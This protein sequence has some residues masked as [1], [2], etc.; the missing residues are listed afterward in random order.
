VQL[1]DLGAL[2][3][4]DRIR[5]GVFSAEDYVRACAERIEGSDRDLGAWVH[6]D[7]DQALEQA[8]SMDE[9]RRRGHPLGLLHGV[10]VGVKD[11]F[12]TSDMPTALGTDIHEGRI[13]ASDAAVVEKL[14]EAGAVI[15]GKTATAEYAFMQPAATRN[16]HDH[17]RTPGGSSSGSA[18]AVAAG[19]V[20]L[21]VGTQTNGSVI[22]PAAYCGVYGFKPSRGIISRRGALQTSQSLDQVGVFG[23]SLGDVARLADALG[24]YDAADPASFLRPRPRMYEGSLAEVPVEPSFAWFDL[25]FNDRLSEAAREGFEELLASLG[26]RVERLPAPKSFQSVVECHKVVHEYELY[27]NLREDIERHGERVSAPLRAVAERARGYGEGRYQ[28]ALAMMAGAED[29][30]DEF[31][32]DYDAILTPAAAGEA[33]ALEAGTGDPIFCTIWTFSGLP[34]LTLPLLVGETGLPVGV[35]MVGSANADDRL[36]RTARWLIRQLQED[37]LDDA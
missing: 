35:Q 8:R 19:Q 24:G 30:F 13:P 32:C 23:R 18:A 21:A 22:R 33:P 2:E 7:L 34:C 4:A 6:F 26:E 16:P 3:V 5:G 1:T 15:P 27:Q 36:L 28:A 31:F 11:I 29:Y 10:A 25:P 14:R 37:E 17:T 12:D 9:L 20:P